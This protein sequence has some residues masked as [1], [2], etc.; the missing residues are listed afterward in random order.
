MEAVLFSVVGIRHTQP[1]PVG[2]FECGLFIF[3]KQNANV[4]LISRWHFAYARFLLRCNSSSSSGGK[5]R[6]SLNTVGSKLIQERKREYFDVQ[7]ASIFSNAC[8]SFGRAIGSV[9]RPGYRSLGKGEKQD[10]QHVLFSVPA[11]RRQQMLREYRR[12]RK[13]AGNRQS[14]G[15]AGL[16][17]DPVSGSGRTAGGTH[18]RNFPSA[19][20]RTVYHADQREL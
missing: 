12:M 8:R 9:S 4:I 5:A 18:G 6:C 20:R 1:L 16:R 2:I 19:D 14:S 10:V 7:R 11:N 15:R 3:S 13:A 17:P